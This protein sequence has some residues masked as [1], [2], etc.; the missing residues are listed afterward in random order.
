[1][2]RVLQVE[3]V[4]FTECRDPMSS[5]QRRELYSGKRKEGPPWQSSNLEGSASPVGMQMRAAAERR[6]KGRE[7][8]R[9]APVFKGKAP[10][11]GISPLKKKRR[12]TQVLSRD[13]E[14]ED[15][16]SEEDEE[17]GDEEEGSDEEAE[18]EEAEDGAEFTKQSWRY[19]SCP[20]SFES[21]R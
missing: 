5:M 13:D 1:V 11:R 16:S 18:D 6:S 21:A 9:H 4:V 12:P 7:D 17:E 8:R 10:A 19:A 15:D 3:E 14:D 20:N 2:C